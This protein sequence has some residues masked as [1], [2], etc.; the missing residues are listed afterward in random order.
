M[1]LTAKPEFL[2]RLNGVRIP[3][4]R[5]QKAPDGGYD[6]AVRLDIAIQ[7]DDKSVQDTDLGWFVVGY[8]QDFLLEY[9]DETSWALLPVEMK[10]ASVDKGWNRTTPVELIG[11][12]WTAGVLQ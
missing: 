2:I 8:G 9:R 1:R 12:L 10:Q 7:N 5:V 4:V 3:N 6:L 11:I